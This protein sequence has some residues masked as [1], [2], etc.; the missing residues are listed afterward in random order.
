MFAELFYLEE[1][2][3][4]ATD[5]GCCAATDVSCAATDPMIELVRPVRVPHFFDPGVH[6]SLIRRGTNMR[7][8]D[9]APRI[10]AAIQMQTIFDAIL[11][12]MHTAEVLPRAAGGT[13][14]NAVLTALEASG[15][16]NTDN[17]QEVSMLIE[18]VVYLSRRPELLK[19]FHD[20]QA[21]CTG[22][23]RQS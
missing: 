20:A 11:A 23:C 15:M 3:C 21:G 4:A 12:E 1:D 18:L 8:P 7:P 14:K 5:V 10:A 22:F 9:I 2:C 16:I 19:I 13:K 6:A 17:R